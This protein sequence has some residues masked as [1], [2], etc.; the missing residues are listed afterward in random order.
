MWYPLNLSFHTRSYAFGERLIPEKL[1]KKK[2]PEGV[3]AETWEVSDYKDTTATVLKGRFAGK[4]LRDLTLTYPD[5][6]VGQGWRGTHFPLL[7]KFLDASHVLPVHLHADDKTAKRKYSEPNGKSEAWHILYAAEDASILAGVKDG[8]TKQ[9]LFDAF[10]AQDYERVM[11]SMSIKTGDTVYVPAGIIHSFGPDTLIFEVQQTSDLT[12]HV[13]P[14]D[15]YGNALSEEVWESNIHETLEELRTHY[16]PRPQAGLAVEEETIKR[17]ICCAGPH[18]AL[19]RWTL[20]D[21]YTLTASPRRCTVLTNI[22]T[23][24]TLEYAGGRE[25]LKRAETCILP[26][27]LEVTVK[28]ECSAELLAC[29]VPDLVEDITQ[30]LMR[31][32]HSLDE[33]KQLGELKG[34]R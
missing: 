30:P 25:T 13:M 27:A 5:E 4:T 23:D 1:G 20:K 19:E 33:I 7:C 18:F 10:K 12:Q 15:V 21:S 2:V 14:T 11:P 17:T 28:P 16:Q 8:V 26:A 34:S 9:E 31:A 22:G 29:Y 6:L 24:V 3:V 32:G